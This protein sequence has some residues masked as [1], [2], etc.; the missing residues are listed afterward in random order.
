MPISVKL[1]YSWLA[2][3][4]LASQTSGSSELV[5]IWCLD[6][7]HDDDDDDERDNIGDYGNGDDH[8]ECPCQTSGN[9]ALVEV[10]ADDHHDGGHDD[11]D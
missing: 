11:D 6:D 7:N 10:P 5:E 8:G 2:S 1:S 4:S 9:S 3:L